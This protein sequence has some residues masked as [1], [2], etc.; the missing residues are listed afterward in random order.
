MMAAYHMHTA[1]EMEAPNRRQSD[2]W[3]TFMIKPCVKNDGCVPDAYIWWKCVSKRPWH[4]YVYIIIEMLLLH[5]MMIL[6]LWD[7][8]SYLTQEKFDKI[9]MFLYER[10][11]LSR[12][13]LKFA[14][15]EL[16]GVAWHCWK[17]YFIHV[18][19]TLL[20]S[21]TMSIQWNLT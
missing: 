6:H 14:A 8:S 4:A 9:E 18:V 16:H 1:D 17:I 7:D 15:L 5:S 13:V 2:E 20:W 10:L 19:M 21:L 3:S 11:F 12:C